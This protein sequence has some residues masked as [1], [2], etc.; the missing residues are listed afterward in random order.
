VQG[1]GAAQVSTTSTGKASSNPASA[2]VSLR[3]SITEADGRLSS[4]AASHPYQLT[5]GFA[6]NTK[7]AKKGAEAKFVPAGGDI[8]DIEVAVPSGLVGNLPVLPRCSNVDFNN[9]HS[10]ALGIGVY[11]VSD[12]PD[13]SALGL[14]LVQKIDG[15]NGILPVPLYNLNPP[16][17][18]VAEFGSQIQGLPFYIDFEARPDKGYKVVANL[19][20]LTQLKR[21]S[22]ATTIIWGTPSDPLHD[23][24]RGS[25]V[26]GLAEFYGISAPTCVPQASAEKKPFLRLP[27]NCTSPLDIQFGFD[28]WT[29]PGEFFAVTSSGPVTEGCEHVEFDASLKAL[30]TTDRADAPSGL[31][32]DLEIRQNEDAEGLGAADLRKTVVAFPVGLTL[33]PATANGLGACSLAQIGYLG[34]TEGADAF[35]NERADCPPESRIGSVK[36]KT[37]LVD[38]VLPLGV[39]S[40]G[41]V[42][43]AAPYDNPFGSLL[44]IYLV[45]YDARTGVIAKLAGKTE[46]DPLTGQLTATF[47]ET[48]QVPIADFEL[49]LFGG[50]T[51]PLRTP[52]VCTKYSTTAVLTPWSAPASGPSTTT[53]SPFGVTQ[54]AA[55]QSSCPTKAEGLPNK[56]EFEAGTVSPIAAAHSPLVLRL[57]RDD[58]SQEFSSLAVTLPPGL[59]GRLA[60]IPY[61]SEA[62]IAAAA[63]RSGR[64][65]QQS[66]S[67]PAASEVGTVEAGVG[68]GPAPYYAGG[69]AYLA[70]PYRGAPLSLA[71]I[72]PA[73]AGPFDLGT[74]VVKTAL[75][76][77]PETGRAT[78]KSD[79]IPSILQGIPLDVRSLTVKLDRPNFILNPTNCNPLSFSGELT[80]TLGQTAPLSQRFQVGECGRLRFQPELSFS[81][82][83]GT[84][85]GKNPAVKAVLTY[86]KRGVYANISRAK[87]T[88]P[89]SEFLDNA[90]FQTICTRVQFAAKACPKGS[91]YGHVRATTPLLDKPLSGPVYL[92]SSS[93]DLPD[94]V[95]SLDGQVPITVVGRI[96]PVKGGRISTVFE[97][98]PDAPVSKLVLELQGGSKGILV[99]S[100]DL[101]RGVHRAL[102]NFTAQNGK[103]IRSKP[104]LKADCPRHKSARHRR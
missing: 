85:R 65:E 64:A 73:V 36:I 86:P 5:L 44:A 74:I 31:H 56:P 7:P 83:G 63:Q 39:G 51:A 8:K 93:H 58:G 30:P 77:D 78:A 59:L 71:V 104:A 17:G 25:C 34:K 60:G 103:Y 23:P 12:C 14:V 13:N 46:T 26:D 32:T 97:N 61:C 19:R 20:N 42:Y 80:T 87:V 89:H 2:G 41:S 99:N 100:T 102:A 45:V 53:L 66:S 57:R 101:C 22:A 24:I 52:A 15:V 27:T 6:F 38:H 91:I 96:D 94:L 21:L 62:A 82:K 92:R 40:E 3:T 9:S 29:V 4:Q 33:N 37:P 49:D 11:T 10:V 69:R 88:L 54:P 47:E 75:Y 76:V 28:N 1:G 50:P 72:S 43:V 16:P 81:L 48:P 84:T 68:A 55:G 90:H 98:L 18:V 35:S 67:C 79:T 70:G 95:A